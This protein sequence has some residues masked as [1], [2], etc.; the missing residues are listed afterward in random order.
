MG[1]I[2]R[3]RAAFVGFGE[4]QVYRGA[5]VSL[6]QLAVDASMQAIADAGLKLD[7]IDGL[8]CTPDPP[9]SRSSS[10]EGIEFVN[11]NYM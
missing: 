6:G 8:V 11:T 10:A 3:N 9:F 7:Q 1:V 5:E 4:S 2:S